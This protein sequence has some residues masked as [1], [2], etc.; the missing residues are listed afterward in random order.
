AVEMHSDMPTME[1]MDASYMAD[2]EYSGYSEDGEAEMPT[3]SLDAASMN[4]GQEAEPAMASGGVAYPEYAQASEE[5]PEESYV[6][7]VEAPVMETMPEEP[8]HEVPT[9]TPA[10]VYTAPSTPNLPTTPIAESSHSTR[11]WMS[12][13]TTDLS[14]GALADMAG[15][16]TNLVGPVAVTEMD[17]A[18]DGEEISPFNYDQLDLEADNEQHT[19]RLE[20]DQ[21][22]RTY[23]TGKLA[24]PDEEDML[25]R[26]R[27]L[28]DMWS[29]ADG[30]ASLFVTEAQSEQQEPGEAIPV[31]A[32]PEYK[33]E[34]ATYA[35]QESGSSLY[36]EYA[37]EQGQPYE[38]AAAD[39][40][41]QEP[42][43]VVFTESVVEYRAATPDVETEQ[44]A[45]EFKV[46]VASQRPWMAY[47]E[48]QNSMEA[49]PPPT[50]A[51][52]PQFL[53]LNSST[54][55]YEATEPLHDDQVEDDAPA[56]RAVAPQQ[57][58]RRASDF[59]RPV[60]LPAHVDILVTG[61]LPAL[62][63]FEDVNEWAGV[64]TQ[65]MGALLAMASAYAQAEDFDAALRVYRKIIRKPGT[66][67]TMLR[68][69]GD[70]LTDIEGL[71]S[72]VP[73]Y[74]QVMGD[75]LLR[76]GRHREA[77]EAYNKLK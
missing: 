58:A 31:A 19:S 60:K 57:T 22:A 74:W 6:E 10:P 28:T 18:M 53:P 77:V 64:N 67:E 36:A 69:I 4:Y 27:P 40:A 25:L 26:S 47:T 56:P 11:S 32:Q 75:L 54:G 68:M 12:N 34:P 24:M 1:A 44:P 23:G 20:A 70:D 9:P 48:A 2:R 37:A 16:H 33:S 41:Y 14:E 50:E 5:S 39:K 65:D 30:D 52:A 17:L 15:E 51:P 38:D 46:R 61:P 45:Q 8:V 49:T 76:L 43:A 13:A 3:P 59:N 66:S 29:E 63:G 72:H 21:M 35:A 62:E 42:V 73:R 7:E 71:A 55:E